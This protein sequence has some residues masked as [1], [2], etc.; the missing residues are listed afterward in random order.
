MIVGTCPHFGCYHQLSVS[1]N[2]N[3]PEFEKMT[4]PECKKVFWQRRNGYEPEAMT[5][6]EFDKHYTFD[7]KTKTVSER[8]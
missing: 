8:R 1:A 7:E 5:E 3:D 6:E 4:C 2:A